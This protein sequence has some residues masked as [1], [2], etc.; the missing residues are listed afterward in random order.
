MKLK[1]SVFRQLVA[2][3]LSGGAERQG[4]SRAV[5]RVAGPCKAPVTVVRHQRLMRRADDHGMLF[6]LELETPCRRCPAC[7]RRRQR[8]WA[9]R[10]A[11]EISCATR[12]WFGTLTLTPQ[13]QYV[14]L[15]QAEAMARLDG[16]EWKYC[17]EQERF[18]LRTR[19]I[20][21]QITKYLKRIRKESGAYL[22]YLLVAEAHKSGEPHFHLLLHEA[23]ELPVRHATLTSQWHLGFTKWKLV[24]D[25]RPSNYMCKYLSK[26]ARARVRASR[27]YGALAEEYRSISIAPRSKRDKT[28]PLTPQHVLTL[29]GISTDLGDT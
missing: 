3:A 23:G 13:A 24:E 14:A 1:W 25:K 20:G 26:D 4:L 12:T 18:N 21:E 19:A 16:R 28:R 22:R 29:A 17:N 7:L 6:E 8:L 2:A 10:A 5:W 11:A 9:G 15:C 27:G